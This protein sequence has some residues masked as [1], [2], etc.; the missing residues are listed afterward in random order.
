MDFAIVL[1]LM[2]CA[3]VLVVLLG[4]KLLACGCE[5]SKV[6]DRRKRLKYRKL[7]DPVIKYAIN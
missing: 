1:T 2:V 6:I 5:F 7:P 4:S 3:L